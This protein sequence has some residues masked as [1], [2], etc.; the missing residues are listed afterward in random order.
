MTDLPLNHQERIRVP[1]TS[2]RLAVASCA[3]ASIC[4]S[5]AL[6]DAS[7][8]LLATEL[9]SGVP[10]LKPGVPIPI[11]QDGKVVFPTEAFDTFADGLH[12]WQAGVLT[13]INIGASSLDLV[14]SIAV[15]SAGDVAFVAA[16]GSPGGSYRGVY[17]T[18]TSAGPITTYHEDLQ[19]DGSPAARFVAMSENGTT[20]FSTIVSSAGSLQRGPIGGSPSVLRSGSGIFY[21]T[22]RL[23]V[24]DAGTV[25]VQMEHTR[26]FGGLGRGILA[27]DTPEQPLTSN[28]TAI[29]QTSVGVQPMPSMNSSG[30]IA[31]S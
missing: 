1:T 13:P 16:R 29:E 22:Q 3:A 9:S 24:N 17:R 31:F 7:F 14:N 30:Q 15:R 19:E 11:S 26:P 28:R 2:A 25:A 6:A 5:A 12:S 20:A 21:N 10:W 4:T 8:S 27:F 18:T 23:D